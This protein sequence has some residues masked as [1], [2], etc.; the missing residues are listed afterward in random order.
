MKAASYLSETLLSPETAKSGEPNHAALNKAFKTDLSMFPWFEL[1]ENKYRL[2]R[3]GI[4]MEGVQ[5]MASPGA[6][7]DG[8]FISLRPVIKPTSR[9]YLRLR[10]EGPWGGICGR[11]CRR[12]CWLPYPRIGEG[13]RAPQIR[14]PGPRRCDIF[15]AQG[16]I[17]FKC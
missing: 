4:A 6:I 8:E 5:N 14:G 16:T 12:W 1:P 15:G 13:V 11:R 17:P 3:F 7:L 2:N 10:M 9:T